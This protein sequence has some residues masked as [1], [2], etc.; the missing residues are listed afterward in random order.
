MSKFPDNSILRYITTISNF[1][2]PEKTYGD[3]SFVLIDPSSNNNNGVFSYVSDNTSVATIDG[4]VVNIIGAGSATIRVIQSSINNYA[5]A[6]LDV[7]FIVNKAITSIANFTIPEK[8]YGDASFTLV[9]PS[10]NNT[11]AFQYIS[12]NTNVA[13]IEGKIVTIIGAGTTTIN[14]IQDACGNYT[15]GSRNATFIVNRITTRITNFTIPLETKT[16]GDA[17]F[18]LFEPSSKSKAAFK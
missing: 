11:S 3:T 2:I 7:S 12:S 4:K 15:D 6:Y 16:Y 14:A 10:S 9:D 5:E 17:S 1:T 8:T 18:E 13:T